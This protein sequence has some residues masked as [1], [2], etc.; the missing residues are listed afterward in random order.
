MKTEDIDKEIERVLSDAR[1]YGYQEAEPGDYK[2]TPMSR[3]EQA[4]ALK[5]L[6]KQI[7]TSDIDILRN[8]MESSMYEVGLGAFT[9]LHWR[10]EQIEMEK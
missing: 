3:E 9:V 4:A 2:Y 1:D 8:R 10:K 7:R 6:I 5:K